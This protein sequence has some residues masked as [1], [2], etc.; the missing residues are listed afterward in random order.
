MQSHGQKNA[1]YTPNNNNNNSGTAV[2]TIG[3]D[4]DSEATDEF[5]PP[6]HK[7]A[8]TRAKT[9]PKGENSAKRDREQR[10]EDR[11]MEEGVEAPIRLVDTLSATQYRTTEDLKR[12]L[13]VGRLFWQRNQAT[14]SSETNTRRAQKLRTDREAVLDVYRRQIE[15]IEAYMA[16]QEQA[17]EEWQRTRLFD[18]RIEAIQAWLRDDRDRVRK[19]RD[20][21][22]DIAARYSDAKLGLGVAPRPLM[23]IP[24]DPDALMVVEQRASKE[25]NT[26]AA[27]D[28]DSN[29][30]DYRAM[31]GSSSSEDEVPRGKRKSVGHERK[32]RAIQVAHSPK[33]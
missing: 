6:P 27:D 3:D 23:A 30:P 5:V 7:Q 29:D 10:R 20:V 13:R 33:K 9:R 11:E 4:D 24:V 28:E 18:G 19:L 8:K 22:D 31:S 16:A 17:L 1:V 14:S 25:S 12:A 15:A 21:R 2:L 32:R 26:A